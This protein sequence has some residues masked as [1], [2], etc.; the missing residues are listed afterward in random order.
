[1]ALPQE[2][3]GE[4]KGIDVP[5]RIQI[6]VDNM[7]GRASEDVNALLNL[8]NPNE[9]WQTVTPKNKKKTKRTT[10]NLQDSNKCPHSDSPLKERQ[11]KR[12]AAESE[13][14]AGEG[15]RKQ[16]ET[17]KTPPPHNTPR[18]EREQK[19]KAD[20][21][22][23]RGKNAPRSSKEKVETTIHTAHYPEESPTRPQGNAETP[24][25]H[26]ER[27]DSPMRVSTPPQTP[28]EEA[29]DLDDNDPELWFETTEDDIT[30]NGKGFR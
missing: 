4:E 15:G 21:P 13:S 10:K 25:E 24:P 27:D 17:E 8:N 11:P 19:D 3:V 28:N 22:G 16:P 20:T 7:L 29:R 1:M 2:A 6:E 5:Y 26:A 9:G 30:T 14:E 23:K 18:V 12:R